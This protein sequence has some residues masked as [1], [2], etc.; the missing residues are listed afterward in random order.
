[1]GDY[2]DNRITQFKDWTNLISKHKQKLAEIM[3]TPSRRIDNLLPSFYHSAPCKRKNKSPEKVNWLYE[4]NNRFLHKLLDVTSGITIVK[5]HKKKHNLRRLSS[6]MKE[7]S[8]IEYDN[9]QFAD[10]LINIRP[11]LSVKKWEAGYKASRKYKEII[12]RPHLAD[13]KKS[14][15]PRKSLPSTAFGGKRPITVQTVDFRI[16][17]SSEVIE[18]EP[19]PIYQIL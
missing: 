12:S 4:E 19:Q 15:T 8:R 5:A 11:T 3:K 9:L 7:K 6:T 17:A 1:M 16:G 13:R 18:K 10:R 14:E 2:I